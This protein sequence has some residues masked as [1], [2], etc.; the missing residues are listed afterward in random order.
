MWDLGPTFANIQ[1]YLAQYYCKKVSTLYHLICQKKK[2]SAC[3]FLTHASSG[4]CGTLDANF[5]N[6][7]NIPLAQYYCDKASTQ[8]HAICYCNE[9]STLYHVVCSIHKRADEFP[10]ATNFGPRLMVQP[11][12]RRDRDTFSMISWNVMLFIISLNFSY[13]SFLFYW[14]HLPSSTVSFG[15]QWK[16]TYFIWSL[17]VYIDV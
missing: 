8:Y 16:I 3:F 14:N 10:L 15:L 4:P 7:P 12:I 1:R 2:Y 5:L 9:V 11:Q 17:T 6:T 13:R